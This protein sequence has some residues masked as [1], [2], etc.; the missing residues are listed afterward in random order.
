MSC[1]IRLII[2]ILLFLFTP[3]QDARDTVASMVARIQRADFEDD[4]ATL[5]RVSAELAPFIEHSALASRVHYWRGFALW[6]R[7]LNAQ[8]EP[9]PPPGIEDDLTQGAAEF[10]KAFA[11]DPKFADAKGGEAYC[12]INLSVLH[13]KEPRGRDWYVRSRALLDEAL[14]AEPE[15]PR[16]LWLLSGYEFYQPVESGGGPAKART[17]QEKALEL[18]RRQKGRTLDPLEP[19][20]GEP[21][22]LMALAYTNLTLATPD[23]DAAERYARSALALAPHWHYVRDILMPRIRNAKL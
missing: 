10:H 1:A 22:L 5:A 15:N 23:L 8:N 19:A 6:R 4:R 3:V 14:A 20:W 18:A 21:E 12:L 2:A 9:T 17:T 11:I 16:L 7:A 13:Q